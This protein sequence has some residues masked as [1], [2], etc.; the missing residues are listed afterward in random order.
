MSLE[1]QLAMNR[2]TWQALQE[3]GVTWQSKL[4]LDF[5]YVAPGEQDA[6]GLLEFLQRETDYDVA[7]SSSG[8]GLLKKKAWAANGTTQETEVSLEILDQR[9][10]W[11]VAAGEE[12]GCDFDRWAAAVPV[13]RRRGKRRSAG[14]VRGNT[15]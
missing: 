14:P 12:N 13:V 1:L 9:V 10:E 3:R 8:G 2:Q 6:K 4:R 7:A 15:P 5:F 11:I